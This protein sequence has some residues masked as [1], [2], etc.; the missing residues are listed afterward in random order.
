VPRCEYAEDKCITST[1]V[2]KEVAPGHFSAWLRI[3]LKEIDLA[4]AHQPG[5]LSEMNGRAPEP[6]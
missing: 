3:Q 2:L 1:I 4:P 5:S 6:V